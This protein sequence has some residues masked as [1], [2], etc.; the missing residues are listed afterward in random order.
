MK[1]ISNFITF[2]KCLTIRNISIDC[3]KHTKKTRMMT[4]FQINTLNYKLTIL[5]ARL[6]QYVVNISFRNTR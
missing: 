2:Y 4:Q 5:F 6:H 3:H 1:L